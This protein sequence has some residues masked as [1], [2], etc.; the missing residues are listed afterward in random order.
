MTRRK[1]A[2]PRAFK[3]EEDTASPSADVART[4]DGDR[5]ESGL[6]LPALPET[7]V[8]AVSC[9]WCC[10]QLVSAD[11]VSQHL[12][13]ECP[14][15]GSDGKSAL[16]EYSLSYGDMAGWAAGTSEQ[17]AWAAGTSRH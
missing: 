7:G 5:P 13:S 6:D 1:Q 15:P 11:E 14:G 10:Q 8:N 4:P 9:R 3:P 12:T 2:Q 17:Y 16:S